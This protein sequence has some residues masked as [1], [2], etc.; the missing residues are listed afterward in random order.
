VNPALPKDARLVE[1]RSDAL[2][3]ETRQCLLPGSLIAFHLVLEGQP[4]ALTLPVSECLVVDRNRRGYLYHLRLPLVDLHEGDRSL[5][6]LFINKG[7]GEPGIE[8]T[9]ARE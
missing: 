7:R 8:P 4:L 2:T 5:I 6:A 9:L 1:L 3:L